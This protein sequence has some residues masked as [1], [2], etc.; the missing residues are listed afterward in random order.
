[1]K[2]LTD[3][4]K[5]LEAGVDPRLRLSVW[6]K[7]EKIARRFPLLEIFPPLPK[8]ESLFTG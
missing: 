1:M 8:T 6:G 3:F 7:G 4:C 5:T 2:N